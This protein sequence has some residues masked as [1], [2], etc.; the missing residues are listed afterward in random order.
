MDER[1]L[2]IIEQT[3][4]F[5]AN[6]YDPLPVVI[7]RGKGIWVYDTEGKAYIDCL[8][9]YSALN[10]GHHHPDL[11][12]ALL[13]QILN[14][15][16]VTSRAVYT[17]N[18]GEFCEKVAGLCRMDKVLPMNTGFEAV[19]TAIKIARKWGY[20]IKGVKKNQAD[21]IVCK[22]NFHGRSTTI[23]GFS[24]TRQYKDGFGPYAPGAFRQVEF[25]DI[26]SLEKAI[27]KNTVAFLVEIIQGEAGVIVPPEGYWEEAQKICKTNGVLFIVDEVQTG[28]GR[29]GY[30]LA[31]FY[32]DLHP[33]MVIL[34]KA[35]GGGILPV[36]AV[37]GRASVMDVLKPGDHGS[38][39]GGNP[40]ACA[41]AIEA[42]WLLKQENLSERSRQLGSQFMDK[43]KNR[44]KS[45]H[46]REIRGRGLM[47]G[48]ELDSKERVKE[49]ALALLEKGML[50]GKAHN[51]IRINPPLI[52]GENI[53]SSLADKLETVL[54]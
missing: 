23:V 30:D 37:A 39:F 29:T 35:L 19:E 24:S 11:V 26:S 20:R 36:S 3:K 32:D 18:L 42:I 14:G 51:V 12:G 4:L 52:I 25:G 44:L 54:G 34:G 28:F 31:H 48:I 16:S 9:S 38:T 43:L 7:V 6:N 45:Q 22:N 53:L 21:I 50:V 17:P 27:D 15:I 1:S 46:I 5:S 8:C 33:D 49:T 13:S 47:I 2:K 10:F 41:V 40:L